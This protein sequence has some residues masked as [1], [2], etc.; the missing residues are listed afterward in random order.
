M[1]W[2][3]SGL[4]LIRLLGRVFKYL[5]TTI[6]PLNKNYSKSTNEYVKNSDYFKG[7]VY[8]K[9]LNIYFFGGTIKIKF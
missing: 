6:N 5:R 4:N 8:F 3:K 1:I 2:K 9:T 7:E